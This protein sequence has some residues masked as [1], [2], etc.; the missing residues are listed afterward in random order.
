MANTDELFTGI[1]INEKVK[2]YEELRSECEELDAQLKDLKR[3]KDTAE[4]EIVM[5]ILS[6]AEQTGIDDLSVKVGNRKYSARTAEYYSIPKE[7]RDEAFQLLRELGHGDLIT[8][9][10]DDRTLSKELAEVSAGYMES[11]AGEADRFPAE[12]EPLLG[13]LRTYTKSALG[14]VI[15][16]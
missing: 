2:A 12:Y 10:V 9:K 6:V 4:H 5:A 1:Q 13:C 7:N 3:Q 14:R 8:E 15:A 16:R 11:H